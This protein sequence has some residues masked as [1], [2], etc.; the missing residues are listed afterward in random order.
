MHA[1][2]CVLEKSVILR[3]DGNAAEAEYSRKQNASLIRQH[4]AFA[5]GM[6][7]AGHLQRCMDNRM[8]HWKRAQKDFQDFA[9]YA[10][11]DDTAAD[12]KNRI[13]AL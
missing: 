1:D 3:K 4:F 6:N 13:D 7:A 5:N 11:T 2:A 10:V 12:L 9:D 8:K